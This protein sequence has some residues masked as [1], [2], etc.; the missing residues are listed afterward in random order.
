MVNNKSNQ[1]VHHQ[2]ATKFASMLQGINDYQP[3]KLLNTYCIS[4]IAQKK[5]IINIFNHVFKY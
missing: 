2:T 3:V 5:S 4:D 1:T